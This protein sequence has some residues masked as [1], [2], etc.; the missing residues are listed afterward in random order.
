ME[1]AGARRVAVVHCGVAAPPA[2]VA[3]SDAPEVLAVGA[4]VAH[5]GHSV[6]A[7]AASLLPDTDIAVAGEGPLTPPGLRWLGHRDDVPALLAGAKVFVQPSIEEGLGTAV[8]EAMLAGVPV[9]VTDAGGLAEVVGEWGIVVPK[10]DPAAL[11][12]GIRRALGGVH[13]PV[14][15]ARRHA[16]ARFGIDRM[17]D[18]TLQVYRSVA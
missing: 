14:V 1:R 13:P 11:A 17:V 15:E 8:V 6:L 10:D 9:V 3:A 18:Q 12:D 5:K 4:R 16:Q 7:A 2:R